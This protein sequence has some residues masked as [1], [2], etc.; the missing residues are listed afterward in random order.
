M[1][2][3]ALLLSLLVAACGTRPASPPALLSTASPVML[4]PGSVGPS[5]SH[6]P[7]RLHAPGTQCGATAAF[8]GPAVARSLPDP[9]GREDPPTWS[10]QAADFAISSVATSPDGQLLA[11]GGA[12]DSSHTAQL[13]GADGSNLATLDDG[14]AAVTCLA[15][16]PDASL[17]AGASRAGDVRL[18]DRHGQLVLTLHG[19]D[20]VFSLAWSPDGDVLATGAIHFPAPT[21]T[22]LIPL[23]GVVRLWDRDGRLNRELGTEATGGKFLNLAWSPDGSMLAAG[24]SDYR[25]WRADGTLVG[26]PRTGGTPAW[27]MAWSPDG[28]AL[29]IGDENGTL[30]IATPDGT[31]RSLSSFDGGINAVGYSP[32][33]ASLAVGHGSIVS[34]VEANDGRTA[35][36]SSTAAA[37]YTIWSVDGRELLISAGAGL[38]LV[39]AGGAPS[40]TLTG[41][42]GRVSAF[43]WDGAVV[44]AATDTG[45]LCSW[46]SPGP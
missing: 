20:P 5:P 34:V 45:R 37:A 7:S 25:V 9:T 28:S 6:G 41:C 3:A 21:A 33:G 39:G 14:G 30:Q 1:K 19:T 4:S 10:A 17:I 23:P 46:R 42:P 24:A 35:L 2:S 18:W 15:W 22:G 31:T 12:A 43:S 36:W 27:A 16:S 40:S 29:A 13:W 26:V 38:A 11:I 8:G 44:V 32:D